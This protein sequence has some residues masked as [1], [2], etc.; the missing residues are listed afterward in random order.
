[1]GIFKSS[2]A[3]GNW[4]EVLSAG[5]DAVASLLIDLDN[6]S[7]IY[8]GVYGGDN[9]RKSANGGESWLNVQVG[10]SNH[11]VVALVMMSTSHI[12]PGIPAAI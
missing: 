1:M 9:F 11:A 8:A 5:L 2:E 3:G 10:S 6:A 4:Q 12:A 7:Y